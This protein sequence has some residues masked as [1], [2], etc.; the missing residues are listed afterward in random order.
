MSLEINKVTAAVLVGALIAVAAGKISSSLYAPEEAEKRG[1]SIAGVEDANAAEAPAA[2]AEAP[3]VDIAALLAGADTANGTKILGKKCAAC[4]TW[5][6]GGKRKTGPNLYN[7][8]D[9]DIAK[10]EGFKYSKA[11]IAKGG[12]WDDESLFKFLTKP[13]KYIPGTK[14]SFSG[15]KK[16]QDTADVI[17]ALKAASGK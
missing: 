17:A 14:M 9:H 12:Q 8:S 11:L 13:K 5:D 6:N 7:I 3:E 15:F 1:F 4:H 2:K 16:P 10:K